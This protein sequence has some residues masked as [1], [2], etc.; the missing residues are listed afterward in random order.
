MVCE[1][2][3]FIPSHGEVVDQNG[4]CGCRLR[5]RV[6]GAFERSENTGDVFVKVTNLTCHFTDDIG[7]VGRK[8]SQCLGAF[9]MLGLRD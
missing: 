8:M 6:E 1:Q 9:G 4:A 2:A 5:R 7:L 3:A